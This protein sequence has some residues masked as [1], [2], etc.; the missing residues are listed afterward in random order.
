VVAALLAFAPA[1]HAF[2]PAAEAENFGKGNE[3]QAIY[4]TPEYQALLRQVSIENRVNA[5]AMQAADP[6]RDMLTHLCST[7]EDGCAGD[8]RLYDW[9]AKGYGIVKKV[10]WTARNGA[11]ISGHVWATK[12][13]PA[14]RPGIV[15]TNGSVQAPEQ[16]Y[17]FV[18]QTLAK[19]GYVVL[20]WDPQGQGQSDTNG[21]GD[22]QNEGA[23]AQSDGRPFFD[24]SEDALNFFFST[25]SAPYVPQKSCETGTSHA[26]K[27]E[28]RVK[29]GF[30]APGYNPFWQLLDAS[31]VGIAGHSYGAAGVSYIGQFDPRVKAIV[32]WDNL[33]SADPN[34][35][36]IGSNPSEQPCPADPSQRAAKPLTKPALGMSA[37]YFIPPTPNTSDPDPLA[38]SDQSFKYSK[39]GVDTGE[40]IIRGGT[41]YDFDWIPNPAFPATL[42]GADMIAWYT[43]AWFD[44]YVRGDPTADA[45]LL[46]DRWRADV[47][48]AA[49]DP[50]GDANMFS[51]YYKSRL[52]I[53]LSGGGRFLCE[54][55]RGGCPALAAAD[56]KPASYDYLTLATSPDSDG[57]GGAA[58]V[59][60]DGGIRGCSKKANRVVP[61]HY[62]VRIVRATVYING[63]RVRVV[64][65]R[66]LKRVRIP[67]AGGGKQRVKIVLL[68]ARG[69]KHTSVRIYK[70][71]KKTKPR[72]V[73]SAHRR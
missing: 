44:K 58:G 7:G 39:A 50:H 46:T 6:E 13:G 59:P 8:V 10:L 42:R 9:E 21:E 53:G 25:P 37:D 30:N 66:S 20:T 28:R 72:R 12:A 64:R 18:A 38:K 51:W 73:R 52:D 43:T 63:K 56:G 54:D 26:A 71:C 70:G 19:E 33:G 48:E 3:R 23:P 4:D 41:H 49:V 67:D 11:T 27:Q 34:E 24:G 35:A 5:T 47:A 1:A 29:E 32:A 61:L 2:D 14:K 65:G 36:F 62:R 16:L 60:S 31:R 15:I 57:P 55:M 69:R 40:L 17:W 68:S 22:D 45:R